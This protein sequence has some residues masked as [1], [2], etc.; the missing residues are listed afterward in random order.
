MPVAL[1][2]ACMAPMLAA[3]ALAVVVHG[4]RRARRMR[5]ARRTDRPAAT[6]DRT[7]DQ[8]HAEVPGA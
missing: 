5:R 2:R 1:F 7:P 6:P 8:P 3:L 4:I